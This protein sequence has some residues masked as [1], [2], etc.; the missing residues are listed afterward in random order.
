MN[1]ATSKLHQIRT[2]KVQIFILES[3]YSKCSYQDPYDAS[4]LCFLNKEIPAETSLVR[5]PRNNVKSM[6][7]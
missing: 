2:Y 1:H 3:T 6:H 5:E 7:T 4:I